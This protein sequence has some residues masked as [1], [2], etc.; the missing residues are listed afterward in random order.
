MAVLCKPVATWAGTLRHMRDNAVVCVVSID[1]H[2]KSF[3]TISCV[4]GMPYDLY[5][6]VAV[7]RPLGGV[8]LTGVNELVYLDQNFRAQGVAVNGYARLSTSLRMTDYS[9]MVLDLDM[10]CMAMVAVDV[11]LYSLMDGRLMLVRLRSEPGRNIVLLEL[12]FIG[13]EVGMVT[14]I[15][16]MPTDVADYVFLGSS[17]TK[18]VMLQLSQKLLSSTS[19]SS[20]ATRG[21]RAVQME[22]DDLDAL[23]GIGVDEPASSTA[24]DV[25]MIGADASAVQE[26][27]EGYRVVQV[28]PCLSLVRSFAVGR[29]HGTSPLLANLPPTG[30]LDMVAIS[31]HGAESSLQ[32]MQ[33]NL[34]SHI[35]A[36]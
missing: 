11:A 32:V 35:L 30:Q 4:T 26:L 24:M 5:R 29:S 21:K 1:L 23:L 9:S 18:S 19:A 8:L 7:P 33:K 14:N 2:N 10:A 17:N 15:T 36:S 27:D 20:G 12:E 13:R 25:D 34:V 16:L 3:A 22:T 31:G 28:M 6:L